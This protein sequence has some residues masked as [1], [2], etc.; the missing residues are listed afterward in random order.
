MHK[1]APNWRSMTRAERRRFRKRNP[2]Y[3]DDENYEHANRARFGQFNAA[4]G[5]YYASNKMRIRELAKTND[6]RDVMLLSKGNVAYRMEDLLKRR[7]NAS[8]SGQHRET[9]R[10][11]KEIMLLRAALGLPKLP[12]EEIVRTHTTSKDPINGENLVIASTESD[13]KWASRITVA[14]LAK[15]IDSLGKR[16]F[17]FTSRREGP[18]TVYS[19]KG[20]KN[21]EAA[22]LELKGIGR[23]WITSAN[24]NGT[25]IDAFNF[26]Q[27][28][29]PIER[30]IPV[31]MASENWD[32]NLLSSNRQKYARSWSIVQSYVT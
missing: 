29:D 6:E 7:R 8:L 22:H 31:E 24:Y 15:I 18:L 28:E 13:A 11:D 23:K 30:G 12:P 16:G 25:R 3:L 4:S 19:W 1:G 21:I 32:G 26:T 2:E 10:L 20:F 9:Q 17:E 27:S 14:N 5:N